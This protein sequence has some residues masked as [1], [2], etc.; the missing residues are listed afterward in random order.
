MEDFFGGVFDDIRGLVSS[1][2]DLFT[3]V[4]DNIDAK[5]IVDGIT[6]TTKA[7]GKI[8]VPKGVSSR[9]PES[10]SIRAGSTQAQRIAD[11]L[12]FERMWMERLR[13]FSNIEQNV[14][15]TKGRGIQ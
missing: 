6:E 5:A 2:D 7:Q 13:D 10:G 12:D 8:T 4:L 1:T 15:R 3:H 11:P 14:A 9:L